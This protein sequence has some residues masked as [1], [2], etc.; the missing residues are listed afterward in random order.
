MT[1]TPLA[2]HAEVARFLHYLARERNLSPHTLAAYQ[3]DLAKLQLWAGSQDVALSDLSVH[4]IRRALAQ[5]HRQD[6]EKASA[7]GQGIE[8]VSMCRAGRLI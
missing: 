4:H 7:W 5:L 1:D 2:Y 8:K 6:D 3:R